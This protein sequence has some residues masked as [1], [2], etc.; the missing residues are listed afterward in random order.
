MAGTAIWERTHCARSR[1][2]SRP[3]LDG[4]SVARREIA[5]RI[6]AVSA[7]LDE[8]L[9]AGFADADWYV[10]GERVELPPGASLSRLASDLADQ[11]YSKAPRVHSE[12]VNRQRPSSNTQAGIRDL[13]HAMISAADKPALGI[14]GFP[15]TAGST[16][17]FSR[18]R[19]Y[20]TNPARRTASA[21]L[22]TARSVKV[23]S[24]LGRQQK[25]FLQVDR[26]PFD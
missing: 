11:R 10:A 16:A 24:P 6:A 21:S 7:E 14:E 19:A 8:E 12:L 3:E 26:R 22:P 5:A 20:I 1:A 17:P 25:P 4:D 18:L 9:R 13:M 15:V 2:Q 23:T